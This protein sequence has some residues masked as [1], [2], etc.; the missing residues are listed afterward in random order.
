M[1]ASLRRAGP[2][3]R[4]RHSFFQS[5]ARVVHFNSIAKLGNGSLFIAGATETSGTV[6]G[7]SSG[8]WYFTVAAVDASGNES[9]FGYEVSK[10]L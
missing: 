3:S 8:T 2:A 4:T 5:R 9:G 6:A 7:L 1:L 10:S